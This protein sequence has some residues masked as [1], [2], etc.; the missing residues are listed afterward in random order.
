MFCTYDIFEV[1]EAINKNHQSWE[2]E[3]YPD[4]IPLTG[5]LICL[6][7]P[8]TYSNKHKNLFVL[9][10]VGLTPRNIGLLSILPLA[11]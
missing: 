4:P 6:E 9:I 10:G 3:V 8:E 1:R 2:G 11:S 5:F 7:Y